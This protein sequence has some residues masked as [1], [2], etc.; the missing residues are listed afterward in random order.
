MGRS[1]LSLVPQ[2][3]PSDQGARSPPRSPLGDLDDR[4]SSGP[5]LGNFEAGVVAAVSNAEISV[6]RGGLGCILG[7]LLIAKFM[8]SYARYVIGRDA[9]ERGGEASEEQDRSGVESP[10]SWA[11]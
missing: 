6:V 9:D 3:H 10:A 4:R 8:P 5:R 1:C 11:A 2:H 7:L